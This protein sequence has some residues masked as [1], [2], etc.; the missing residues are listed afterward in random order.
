MT[1]APILTKENGT[2]SWN[3]AAE[4]LERLIRAYV[5]WPSVT[6][7][8]FEQRIKVHSGRVWHYGVVDQA[9]G[10]VLSMEDQG[11]QVACAQGVLHLGEVQAP[12]KRVMPARSWAQGARVTP[13]TVLV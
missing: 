2:R 12:G 13:G 5:G 11:V 1:L 9:P 3:E 10:T 4:S 8:V 7:P 6:L